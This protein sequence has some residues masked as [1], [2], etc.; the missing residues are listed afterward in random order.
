L[1]TPPCSRL[2]PLCASEESALYVLA[3][4]ERGVLAEAPSFSVDAAGALLSPAAVLGPGLFRIAL[5]PAL[6]QQG[7][8]ERQLQVS[9]AGELQSCTLTLAPPPG[10]DSPPAQVP[11]SVD[12][13]AHTAVLLGIQLGA[14]SN[15]GRVAG[16]WGALH[17][18][19]PLSR[20]ATGFRLEAELA[21][22]RSANRLGEVGGE[23]LELVLQSWPFSGGVRYLLAAGHWQYGAAVSSGID[24]VNVRV[25]R[26]SSTEARWAHPLLLGGALSAGFLLPHAELRLELGYAR[27][28]VDTTVVQGNAA[29][30]RATLGYLF[31][32]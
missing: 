11:K 16:P 12:A 6:D 4:D 17:L 19:L 23:P 8:V 15:W 10:A 24:L 22:T 26:A 28:Y 30:W 32:L 27:A 25:R 9:L 29:G 21:Y 3:L 18:G 1:D 7:H 14:S 5:T 31:Q 2:L 20:A 13:A